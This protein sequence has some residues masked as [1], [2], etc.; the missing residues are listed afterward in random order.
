MSDGPSMPV[1][2]EAQ[3]TNYLN[4]LSDAYKRSESGRSQT[5]LQAAA[6]GAA[7]TSPSI[8]KDIS[9]ISSG[10][11]DEQKRLMTGPTAELLYSNWRKEITSS[12][13]R[14]AY[15]G[16]LEEKGDSGTFVP[17]GGEF[18]PPDLPSLEEL[19]SQ[20]KELKVSPEVKPENLTSF[21]RAVG[22]KPN[23]MEKFYMK[24]F[25]LSAI[26]P[27]EDNLGRVRET[28]GRRQAVAG[29]TVKSSTKS[30]WT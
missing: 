18:E 28:A 15:R 17:R 22:R 12:A 7:V 10:L 4:W 14:K 2:Y 27:K 21:E 1:D 8:A 23:A 29:A 5:R 13:K 25:G 3:W 9:S 24:K 16:P 6:G 20:S 19:Y 26:A 11:V 30:P